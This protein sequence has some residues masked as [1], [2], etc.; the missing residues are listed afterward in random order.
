M[1]KI[2]IYPKTGIGKIKPMHAVNNGPVRSY[3]KRSNFE[4][5]KAL[6][7]PFVRNHD[8]SLSEAYGSSHVVD[9]HC[10]FPDFSKD[11]SDENAYDFTITDGYTKTIID[12]GSK[13]FY[14]LGSSIEHWAKKYGTIV[15]AD[16]LKWSQICEHIIM[17]YN[18]GWAGGF[19]YGI[20]YWEIWNEPDLDGD[21]CTDKRTWSGTRKQFFEF[22][23]VAANY[24]KK[25]FPSLKIGGPAICGN[26]YFADAFLAQL[27][28]PLDFFSYHR[29]AYSPDFIAET[30]VKVKELLTKHGYENAECILNEWNY[31]KDWDNPIE[32]LKTIKS[33]K[34]AAFSAAAMCACQKC[35]VVD[36][37]MYYDARV[38][39]IYN[40]L[41][42]SDT[43]E[44]LKGY[45]AFK[46]FSVLYQYGTEIRCECD[47]ENIYAV[48][49]KNADG[50]TATL[51]SYFTDDDGMHDKTVSFESENDIAAT[52]YLLD[53]EKDCAPIKKISSG[54]SI[55]IRP[56]TV[57]LICED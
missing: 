55:T 18:E 41:F 53:D 42:D 52:L 26:L 56:N 25:R 43:L 44:P 57:L 13:V 37:L 35:G 39:K 9:V 38:E 16:F 34:G 22:Y 17:H 11:V 45:Y 54:S 51:I 24:L 21:D 3:E 19:H 48:S 50:K 49:A 2:T 32:Y 14:R 47:A 31:I 29:Y 6:Q 8:A 27:N 1:N 30:G 4:A 10:I 15:P 40:G 7:I 5:F 33:I 28:A 36:M 12:A 23:D 46:M 20:E